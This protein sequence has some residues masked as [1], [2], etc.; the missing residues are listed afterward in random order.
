MRSSTRREIC[1]R[2]CARRETRAPYIERPYRMQYPGDEKIE[3][4]D[5]Y[6]EISRASKRG[7]ADSISAVDPRVSEDASHVKYQEAAYVRTVGDAHRKAFGQFFTPPE[8]A[9][10]M[11]RWVLGSGNA[12]IH[13]PAFG[14]GTFWD[15]AEYGDG[16]AFTGSEV[17]P[18][19]LHHWRRSSPSSRVPD[20]SREDY[21]LSWGR[22]FGNIV[23]NPPYMRFQKFLN[24]DLVFERFER[25]LGIRL[26]GYTNTAS[27]FLL[28]SLSELGRAGRLAYIMPLEFLNT[29]YGVTVKEWLIAGSHLS[30]IIRFDCERDVFPD[31]VTSVGILLYDSAAVF[32]HL[33]LFTVKS[34]ESLDSL[35]DTRPAVEIPYARLAPKD[36]WLP[37]FDDAR[38]AV[39]ADKTVPLEYYGRFQRGI[40]TGANDF[41]VLRP[42]RAKALGLLDS[43]VVP[44]ITKS[45]QV[46][47]PFFTDADYD[48]LVSR[49]AP[50]LL[51]DAGGECSEMARDYIRFGER[52]GFDRRFITANR[53][54]WY[55]NESRS[56]PPLLLGTFSRG[57][58]KVV[59]NMSRALNLT[60]FHG[61]RPN[62]HGLKYIDHLFLYLC[63]A[64]GR[65]IVSLSSR[66]YGDGLDKFEPN[67][68]NAAQVPAPDVFDAVPVDRVD[69]ALDHVRETG[70]AP[71]YLESWYRKLK[72]EEHRT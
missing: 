11:V 27:A 13:D 60:C 67:D 20:V 56:P 32:S 18:R 68:L 21:L 59:R 36:K 39:R 34:I 31:A 41:F 23:C 48:G 37:Y 29:G 33:K 69:D 2:V 9:R 65:E 50:S 58:Y 16:V 47:A 25:H 51:F 8:V 7:R 70:A 54:P 35:L 12:A 57:G 52:E 53:V 14:L 4:I 63:S 46:R 49:D 44:S 5:Q 45:A 55:K 17:D 22:R 15:A 3:A 66:R 24:R 26:L 6:S 62:L 42:S 10:F 71:N 72:R 64:T 61:F 28:K 38:V 43:E 19:I 1:P 40:A 30:A